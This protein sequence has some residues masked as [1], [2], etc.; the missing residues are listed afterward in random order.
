MVKESK[1]LGKVLGS[2]K[3]TF[4]TSIPK[5]KKTNT[6]D[7]F[8]PISY[9]NMIYKVIMKVIAL[10]LKPILS[11]VEIED[12]FKFLHNRK[13]HDTISLAQEEIYSIKKEKQCDFALKLDL[14]NA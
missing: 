4:I 5:K 6:Y 1:K 12:Q 8:R 3:S 7:D 2:I 10:R 13:I 9:C 11:D 14:S